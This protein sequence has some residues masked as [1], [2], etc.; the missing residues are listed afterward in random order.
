MKA[1][2]YVGACVDVGY[3][4]HGYRRSRLY[5][6]HKRKYSKMF[7]LCSADAT[8]ASILLEPLLISVAKMRCEGDDSLYCENEVVDGRLQ[9]ALDLHW[10][11]VCI[12]EVPVAPL[13]SGWKRKARSHSAD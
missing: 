6:G 10:I 3:R 8:T 1:R 9:Q 11:Y 12:G 2:V 13:S 5:V 4:W 7:I